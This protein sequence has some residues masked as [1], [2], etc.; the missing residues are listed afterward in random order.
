MDDHFEALKEEMENEYN[1]NE[2]EHKGFEE[3]MYLQEIHCKKWKAL[4]WLFIYEMYGEMGKN[5]RI[6]LPECVIDEVRCW[7][8]DPSG[9]YMGYKEKFINYVNVK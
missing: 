2:E 5:N 7:F 6:E 8:P 9:E 3:V 4:H 1:E